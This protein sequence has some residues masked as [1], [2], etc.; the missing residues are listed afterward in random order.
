VRYSERPEL[1]DSISGLSD[2]VWPEYNQHGDVLNRYWARLYDVFPDWQFVLW[3][4]GEGTV[5]AEGHTI[6]VAWNG[7][8]T[9]LGPGIDAVPL[10]YSVGWLTCA[11]ADRLDMVMVG[12]TG[13]AQDRLPAGPPDARPDRRA[14][15]R[16]PG[17]SGRDAGAAA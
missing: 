7:T 3:D 14:G 8:D 1:W 2:E 6:P 12:W 16:Q 17:G 10:E 4:P 9:G 5:L 15:S 11:V 13:A